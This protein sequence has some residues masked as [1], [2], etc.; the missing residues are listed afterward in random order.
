MT[1]PRETV[2]P[3]DLLE[4][5]DLLREENSKSKAVIRRLSEDRN[6]LIEDGR[7]AQQGLRIAIA[8]T[9]L[10]QAKARLHKALIPRGAVLGFLLGAML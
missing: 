2:R 6:E 3:Q 5:R 10:W 7:H 8:E 1:E 9:E 4:E